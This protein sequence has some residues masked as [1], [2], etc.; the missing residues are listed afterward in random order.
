MGNLE[1]KRS[2]DLEP[3]PLWWRSM[4]G[5]RRGNGRWRQRA[6][7]VSERQRLSP[8]NAWFASRL[9]LLLT[10]PPVRFL[11]IFHRDPIL[12]SALSCFISSIWMKSLFHQVTDPQSKII[13]LYMP[14]CL[15]NSVALG[16]L[17]RLYQ[18]TNL[19]SET[20]GT[21]QLSNL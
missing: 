8:L 10:D 19:Y 9:L 20:V 17:S 12:P 6:L 15:S 4:Y 16:C 7:N 5:E 18:Q 3:G 13:T 11:M 2:W 21:W 14:V 1:R